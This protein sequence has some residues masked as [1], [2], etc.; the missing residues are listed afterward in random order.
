MKFRGSVHKERERERE[1][2]RVQDE[3]MVWGGGARSLD[4]VV[5]FCARCVGFEYTEY[6]WSFV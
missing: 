1:R 4:W 2:E 5:T 3:L 6:M